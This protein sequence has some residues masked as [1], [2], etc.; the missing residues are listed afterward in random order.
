MAGRLLSPNPIRRPPMLL[1]IGKSTA[2]AMLG[3]V[4]IGLIIGGYEAV[5]VWRSVRV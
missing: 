4:C 2:S 3:L 5:Q 1:T